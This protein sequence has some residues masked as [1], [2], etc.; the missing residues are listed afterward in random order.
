MA[1]VMRYIKPKLKLAPLVAH[2]WSRH[3]AT[4]NKKHAKEVPEEEGVVLLREH[5]ATTPGEHAVSTDQ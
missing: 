5:S 1:Y 4:K 2:T 3:N